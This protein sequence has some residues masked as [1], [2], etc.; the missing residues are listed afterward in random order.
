MEAEMTLEE[1]NNTIKSKAMKDTAPGT[2]GIPTA[3]LPGGGI[4]PPP[5][6][7]DSGIMTISFKE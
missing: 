3:P 5:R 1:F 6:N 4:P 7:G 2:E